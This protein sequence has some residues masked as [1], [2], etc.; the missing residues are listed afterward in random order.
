VN[1]KE[2]ISKLKDSFNVSVGVNLELLF[3]ELARLAAKL[4][5]GPDDPLTEQYLK[6]AKAV[7]AA[8][9]TQ[10]T[11]NVVEYGWKE[12]ESLLH[13]GRVPKRKKRVGASTA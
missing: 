12:I 11:A 6:Q 8:F 1:L 7:Y 5:I 10:S 9:L 2:W 13:T 3:T 4:G